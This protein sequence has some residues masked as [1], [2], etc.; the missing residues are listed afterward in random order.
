MEEVRDYGW[1]GDFVMGPVAIMLPDPD[2]NT[3][4]M[5]FAWKQSNNGMVFVSSPIGL[6][7]LEDK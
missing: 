7:W 3:F 1:E 2:R 6:P 5:G 4:T